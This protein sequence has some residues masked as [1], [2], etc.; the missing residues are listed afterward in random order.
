V[1]RHL[2]DGMVVSHLPFGPTA[3]FGLVNTV[4]R[5]DIKDK[6]VLG[7]MKEVA[8]HLILDNFTTSLGERTANILKH[9]FPMPKEASKRV[10]TFANQKDYIS[11]RCAPIPS[12]RPSRCKGGEKGRE[13]C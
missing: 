12:R 4:L 2:A 11:F 7:K 13:S 10:I 5:H 6:A 3:Y 1:I 9:L 8:P